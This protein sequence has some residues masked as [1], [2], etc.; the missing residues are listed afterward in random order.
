KNLTTHLSHNLC[1][2][3]PKSGI[4]S[5]A[6]KYWT[7]AAFRCIIKRVCC[8]GEHALRK[9][10]VMREIPMTSAKERSVCV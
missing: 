10:H 2:V 5:F 8:P 7:F 4:V 1:A 3:L 9:S 6:K